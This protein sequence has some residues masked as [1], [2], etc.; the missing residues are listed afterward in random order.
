[1]RLTGW[2]AAAAIMLG[3][4][5]ARADCATQEEIDAFI[6]AY[7]TKAPAKALSVGGSMAD[8]ACTQAKLGLAMADVMGPVVGYKAG[9]TSKPAQDRFGVSE[10]VM[11]VLYHDTLLRDGAEVALP[12]GSVPVFEADLI[13][14]IAD[15]GINAASTGEEAMAHIASLHPFIELP[16][17]M[18]AKGEPITGVTLTAMGVG[19]RSGVVGEGLPV[20]DPAAAY[21][22]LGAMRVVLRAADGEVLADVPG[23]AVLGHPINAVLWLRDKGVV[24]KAGDLVSVGSFGPLF[25][26]AKGKGGAS[27]TYVGLPGDPVVSVSFKAADD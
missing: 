19:A 6:E 27:V 10:P 15:A 25:P 16:D 12:W 9:L 17:L 3:A 5:G 22:A 24:F 14:E 8:A 7:I 18:L 21:A 26:P 2:L 4:T 1:M 20:T 13:V 23:T 11:G